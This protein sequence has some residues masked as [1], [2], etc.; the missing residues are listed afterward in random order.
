V[1]SAV[2]GVL[3]LAPD[4]IYMVDEYTAPGFRRRGITRQLAIASNPTLLGLGYREVVGIHRTDNRDTIA[5]T[6]AKNIVTI[7]RLTRTCVFSR[8]WFRYEPYVAT[9]AAPVEPTV[10]RS[11]APTVAVGR[12]AA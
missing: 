12:R 10:R 2:E 8:T 5:A 4:Q 9:S 11:P 7:G 6:Q 3:T 1:H